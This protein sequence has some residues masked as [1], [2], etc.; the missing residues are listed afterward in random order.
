MADVNETIIRKLDNIRVKGKTRPVSIYEIMD[1]YDES[2]F[3]NLG[4]VIK[5]HQEGFDLYQSGDWSAAK[6]ILQEAL[7]LNPEDKATWTLL[8]RCMHF[9]KKPPEGGWD[10]V[11]EMETK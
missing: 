8:Q 9:E 3:P 6:A 10:G 1:F 11:W 7:H 2:T 4:K 5:H